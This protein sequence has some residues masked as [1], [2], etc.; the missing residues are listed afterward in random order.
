MRLD[1]SPGGGD[2]CGGP[3]PPHCLAAAPGTHIDR[4]QLG[5]DS[6]RVWT[7]TAPHGRPASLSSLQYRPHSLKYPPSGQQKGQSLATCS[8]QTDTVQ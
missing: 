6:G 3:A 8:A 1:V 5:Q 7:T 2:L 4:Q